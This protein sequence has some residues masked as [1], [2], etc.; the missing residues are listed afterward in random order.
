MLSTRVQRLL[1]AQLVILFALVCGLHAQEL[2]C[3]ISVNSS[4]IQGTNRNVFNT[5]QRAMY[6]FVNNTKWTPNVF[7]E[8]E[9]IECSVIIT[10]NEQIGSDEYKGS[11]NLQLRRPIYGTSY[12]SP[13]INFLD[14]NIQFK[15]IEN[16]KIEFNEAAHISNL[17]SLLAYYVYMILGYDYDTF[18]PLGGTP[19]FE[20][21]EQ[22]VSNAQNA[23]ERGWRA[24]EGSKKNR[25]WMVENMLNDKYRPLRRAMY[26]YHLK[27]L[28]KMS[29]KL[30]TGR[31]NIAR[32]LVDVQKVYRAKPD[33]DMLALQLF[34]DAKRDEL[35]NIFGGAPSTEKARVVN[36]LVD[37][38]RMNAEKYQGILKM[39]NKPI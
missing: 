15:Y 36:I 13:L 16:E 27:G 14:N 32:A 37:I 33:Q 3:T 10:L 5:M 6:E 2:N 9:R 30:T 25:Y 17:S 35:I 22:I 26:A 31:D 8:N 38:D 1:L 23:P 4:K 20:K 18:A 11:L 24:Y 7:A 19:Y 34:L 28:D 21:A 39:K 29:D 12:K